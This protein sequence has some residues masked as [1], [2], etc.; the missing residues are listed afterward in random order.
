[1]TRRKRR[2]TRQLLTRLAAC[3][4]CV[5]LAVISYLLELT[6]TPG[7]VAQCPSCHRELLVP[8]SRAE[9]GQELFE[10]ALREVASHIKDSDGATHFRFT[11]NGTEIF[12][13]TGWN[14]RNVYRIEFQC[15]E[16]DFAKVRA[17]K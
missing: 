2:P 4:T 8:M 13:D 14:D 10:N 3:E 17:M 6:E 16:K 7:A 12:A 15:S 1:M 9:I 11:L 5:Y